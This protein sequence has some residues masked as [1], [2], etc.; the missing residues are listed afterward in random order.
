MKRSLV[1]G[2]PEA[3]VARQAEEGVLRTDAPQPNPQLHEL[4]DTLRIQRAKLSAGLVEAK[5]LIKKRP[6]AQI[7]NSASYSRILPKR[8]QNCMQFSHVRAMSND[9]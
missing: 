3:A 6:P 9:T 2:G 8:L 5:S 4:L 1:H 7:R